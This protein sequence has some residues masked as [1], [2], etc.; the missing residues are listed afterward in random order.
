LGLVIVGLGALAAGCSSDE[1]KCLPGDFSCGSPPAGTGGTTSVSQGGS[2]GQVGGG[3]GGTGT[4]G[5]GGTGG[6]GATVNR[7][8]ALTLAPTTATATSLG[9]ALSGPTYGI[10]GESFVD[11]SA[12]GNTFEVVPGNPGQVCVRG[13]LD[14]VPDASSYGTHWGVD[15]GFNL[16]QSTTP[17]AGGDA[18]AGADAGTTGGGGALDPLAWNPP[19]NVIGFSFVL[20]GPMIDLVRVRV[21]PFGLDP[22]L[23]SSIY[24]KGFN[25]GSIVSGQPA[26]VRF[27]EVTQTC[28]TPGLAAAPTAAGFDRISWNLPADVAPATARPFDFCISDIKPILAP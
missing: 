19:A 5:T 23:E 11:R 14:I 20:T 22:T 3:Q 26:D 9:F 7:G 16:N 1:S 27:T 28:W 10:Q 24:C 6:G 13:N 15:F 2:G 18:D 8:E 25:K 4:A 17:T 21:R 12:Q